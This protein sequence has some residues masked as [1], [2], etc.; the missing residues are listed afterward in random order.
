MIFILTCL[1]L[2]LSV[3]VWAADGIAVTSAQAS[4]G[5]GTQD[6]TVSGIGTPNGVLIFLS[7]ATVDRDTSLE[8]H[9]IWGVGAYDG[10]RQRAMRLRSG[11]GLDSTR[12]GR[13][14]SVTEC[15]ETPT[16]E[17]QTF[18]GTATC[19]WITNGVRLTWTDTPT[20]QFFMVVVFFYGD[21]TLYVGHFDSDPDD[22]D[23]VVVSDPGATPDAIFFWTTGATD[24]AEF[25]AHGSMGF[26]ASDGMSIQQSSVGFGDRNI[27][28]TSEISGVT[29]GQ[30]AIQATDWTQL[31]VAL[32]IT[33]FDASGFT[34]TTR[35][36]GEDYLGEAGA[37]T[38]FYAA[39]FLAGGS[40]PWVGVED[41]PTSTGSH[42][43]TGSGLTPIFAL[44]L[45]SNAES[46]DTRV[47][48]DDG[49]MG[50]FGICAM[51]AD[52]QFCTGIMSEDAQD[53]S[54]VASVYD[55]VPLVCY[56]GDQ[57]LAYVASFSRFVLSGGGGIQLNYATAPATANKIPMLVI[58][59]SIRQNPIMF[60]LK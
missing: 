33:S 44:A 57:T 30:Y 8:T 51:T 39:I 32:E 16:T 4:T 29:S 47:E 52:N 50:Y 11:D 38:I 34:A 6:I 41:T 3:P 12:T 25:H 24:N 19:A 60:L 36:P 17:G 2:A 21:S 1:W 53:I 9:G 35:N 7:R 56:E 48:N 22:N 20:T 45:P 13:I 28:N 49:L 46:L 5:G 27:V 43:H 40:Q 59:E 15:I 10:T 14:D 31:R 37:A 23:A 54:D 26:A 18:D 42:T 55:N 58:G